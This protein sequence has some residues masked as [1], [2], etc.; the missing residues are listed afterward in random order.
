LEKNY[1]GL[2]SFKGLKMKKNIIISAAVSLLLLTSCGPRVGSPEAKLKIINEQKEIKKEKLT[3]TQEAN[4]D[5]RP[6]WCDDEMPSSD[7]AIYACGFGESSNLNIATTKANLFA[8]NYLAE[9]QGTEISAKA[10]VSLNDLS[11]NDK[12]VFI[13]SIKNVT[14]AKQISGFKKIKSQ[15]NSVNGKYQYYVL[16]ELPIGEANAV[17]MKKLKNNKAIK[18]IEGHEKAMADLE[19]EIEKRKK[20]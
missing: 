9:T 16:F 2:Y 12:E 6:K 11:E 3:E 1:F 14:A 13:Q 19:A 17:I 18:A 8:K 10:E 7:Y 15:V 5:K 4:L 20:K